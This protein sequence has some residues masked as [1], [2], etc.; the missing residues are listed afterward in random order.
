MRYVSVAKIGFGLYVCA[1]A[2]GC[3]TRSAS[4]QSTGSMD[5]AALTQQTR[6]VSSPSAMANTAQV[7]GAPLIADANPSRTAGISSIELSRRPVTRQQVIAW[8]N[9]GLRDEVIIDRIA[10]SGTIFHLSTSDELNLRD[11]GVSSDVVRAMR[12]TALP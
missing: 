7:A 11:A 5:Q 12:A 1:I 9:R 6:D 8:T 2:A 3:E 4:V 10:C